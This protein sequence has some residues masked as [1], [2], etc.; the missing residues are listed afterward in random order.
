MRLRYITLY[1]K[2]PLDS[3]YSDKQ[4]IFNFNKSR[5]FI[6]NYISKAIR[7][8]KF[9]TDG[10]FNMISVQLNA[11]RNECIV[12]DYLNV[13]MVNLMVPYEEMVAYQAMEDPEQRYESYLT[14]LHRGYLLAQNVKQ[15]PLDALLEIHDQLRK[16][17]YRNEW[18]FKKVRLPSYDMS[19]EFKCFFTSTEFRLQL[20]AYK[21]KTR[22]LITSGIVLETFPDEL[23]Y[24]FQFKKI[25]IKANILTILG[26]LQ[27]PFFK[28]DLDKI[29]K[30]IFNVED[31]REH[32]DIK[33]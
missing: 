19:I 12:D 20:E 11:N 10:S 23:C 3:G 16:N 4:F 6:Y 1:I 2:P 21:L 5:R 22:E 29:Q 14:L 27:T 15:I 31:I 17:N 13:L 32:F 28:I 9:E 26:F 24:D 8:Y 33:I 18:L 7:K 25:E 30:G